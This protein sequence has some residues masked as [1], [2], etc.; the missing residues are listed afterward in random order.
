VLLPES[1]TSHPPEIQ[2]AV[3]SHELLHVK[4]RDWI[5]VM[6][7]EVLRAVFWFHPG[8]WWLVARVRLAR[9]EVVDELTVRAAGQ[10]RVYLEALLAF[11][12]AAPFGPSA[13]F[14]RQRHLFRRMTLISKE[15]VM[16]SRRIVVSCAVL[17]FGVAAG[18]WFALEAFP[19]AQAPGV[20]V[21]PA[22]SPVQ[23][24]Q[25]GPPEHNAKVITP[26]NPIPRRTYAVSPQY[27]AGS[28][29]S[30]AVALHVTINMLGRVGE[31]RPVALMTGGVVVV[32]DAQ[33]LA[34]HIETYGAGVSPSSVFV[35]AA[36]EAVRQWVYEPP[37]D[38]PVSFEL[39]FLFA[40]GSETTLIAYG[41]PGLV[42]P[43]R[44]ADA[45]VG[46]PPPPPPA[47]WT[48]E[49]AA[50]DNPVRIGG[51][52][53]APTKVKDAKAQYTPEAL[54][55][56]VQGVVFLEAIV[57]TSGRVDYVRVLRG[58]QLLDQAAMDAVKEWEFT[59][60]F[61]NGVA[62]PVMLTVQI[63]FTLK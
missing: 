11:A 20:V 3:L 14:A 12:D 57:G 61:R 10:R 1:L 54:A 17:V 6:A 37:A 38:A 22:L 52:V 33:I 24:S 9:E 13:A 44:E 27:P 46:A 39:A 45:S 23:A 63:S 49:G 26:E 53:A 50:I 4:R 58:I 36:V 40:P 35:K 34:N 32:R 19:L 7:E 25:S 28:A 41:P 60:T 59:P 18:S 16:S 55:A 31:V 15:A 21:Q 62:V 56:H 8:M 29:D 51:D 47:P 48:R 30:A 2:R 42:S 43:P 5:W